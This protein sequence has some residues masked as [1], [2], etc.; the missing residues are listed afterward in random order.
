MKKN[1]VSLVFLVKK[2]FLQKTGLALFVISILLLHQCSRAPL[3]LENAGPFSSPDTLVSPLKIGALL[4]LSG[5]HKELGKH[6]LNA[7]MLGV[8]A[9]PHL[10]LVIRDTKGTA[11]GARRA[12]LSA[13]KEGVDIFLGP[14][15]AFENNALF[16][17]KDPLSTIIT[18]SPDP[19]AR[20]EGVYS[21]CFPVSAQGEEVV[22]RCHILGIREVVALLPKTR[23]G[24]MMASVLL[25]SCKN[26]HLK[27]SI[28]NHYH[29]EDLANKTKALPAL[30][31]CLDAF[32]YNSNQAIFLPEGGEK[33]AVLVELFLERGLSCQKHWFIGPNQWEAPRTLNNPLMA[34]GWYVGRQT[35]N[36][37]F[38]KIYRTFFNTP[39]SKLEG[40][41]YD[42][43]S[44]V[45]HYALWLKNN[46][47]SHTFE[48]FQGFLQRPQGFDGVHGWWRFLS[49]GDIK[50][51]LTTF[52]IPLH[53]KAPDRKSVV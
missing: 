13:K 15:F 4:P 5:P 39:S 14:L 26:H 20:T 52:Q 8:C 29:P 2:A 6:L 23:Y 43:V 37:T 16:V 42:S 49:N 21:L 53:D 19:R 46:N 31:P 40:L 36:A 38:E 11:P 27:F 33:L 48:G 12:F 10:L 22:K 3:P 44:L 28:L 47:K 34:G 30:G 24:H 45:N 9:T 51:N 17:V 50:R 25:E 35:Q 18:F 1:L 41:A 32:V 7:M